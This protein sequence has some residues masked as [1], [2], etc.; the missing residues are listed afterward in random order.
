MLISSVAVVGLL[1]GV[2]VGIEGGVMFDI[3]E[4][5]FVEKLLL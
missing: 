1:I 5:Y 2:D 3:L 4:V